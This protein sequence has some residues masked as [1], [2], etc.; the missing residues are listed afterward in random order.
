MENKEFLKYKSGIIKGCIFN[1]AAAVLAVAATVCLLFAPN[2][3]YFVGGATQRFS[4]FDEVLRC[5]NLIGAAEASQ[6][7]NVYQVV[8]VIYL[9]LGCA[10]AVYSAVKCVMN[11]LRGDEY[12]RESC[13]KIKQ[14]EEGKKR[15]YFKKFTVTNLFLSGVALE[16]FYIILVKCAAGGAGA[17]YVSAANG[18]TGF[19]AFFILFTAAYVAVAYFA[20]REISAVKRAI[21]SEENGL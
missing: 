10:Y 8:S 9:A 19:I 17:G 11:L 2:F 15:V 7:Y 6:V 14:P 21:L 18:V 3:T 4:L 13:E 1:T 16:I 20:H 5:F 12:V